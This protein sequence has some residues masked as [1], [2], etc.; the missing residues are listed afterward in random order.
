MST[1][2]CLLPAVTA[3]CAGGLTACDQLFDKGSKQNIEL[4]DK[5]VKANDVQGAI[6]LYEASLDGSPK[7]AE[8]HYKLAILYADKIGSPVDAMHHFSRY[9]ALAPNG[10]HAKEAK[11]YRRE[12]EQKLLA[13]YAKGNPLNQDEAAKLRNHN[14]SLQKALAE[15]KAQ[16]PPLLSPCH[17]A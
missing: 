1:F 11:D 9:L 17:R 3:L 16:R 13:T 7:T 15:L 10:T 14:L 2:R 8:T 5:R 6:K 4:A 12:G